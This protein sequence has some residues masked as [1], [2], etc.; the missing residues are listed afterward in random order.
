MLGTFAVW[1]KARENGVALAGTR[2]HPTRIF[3]AL[4]NFFF[5]LKFFA[6]T[7]FTILIFYLQIKINFE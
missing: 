2:G 1:V 4:F 5:K 6:Y 3:K 7:F